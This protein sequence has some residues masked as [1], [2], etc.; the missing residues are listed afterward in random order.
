MQPHVEETER[1]QQKKTK[2]SVVLHDLSASSSP[3]VA[4]SSG[5]LPLAQCG[6]LLP[7]LVHSLRS[8]FR[9]ESLTAVQAAVLPPALQQRDVVA[10]SRT[11]SGKT[12]AYL[13]PALQSLL[14]PTSASASPPLPSTCTVLILQPTRELVLQTVNTLLRLSPSPSL[15][16]AAVYGGAS[17]SAQEAALAG[18]CHVL[19]A[20]PGRLLDFMARRC[21]SL[22]RVRLCVLDECDAMLRLGFV[23]D[24]ETVMAEMRQQGRQ[25]LLFSATMP[26][27]V[28]KVSSRHLR[29]PVTL[30]LVTQQTAGEGAGP[31]QHSASASPSSIRHQALVCPADFTSRASLIAA[32][33]RQSSSGRVI[34]F[35]SSRNDCSLLASHPALSPIAAA[36]HGEQSQQQRESVMAAFRSASSSSSSPRVL[37]ATDL[38]ARG[39]D[40]DD[41]ELV[42]HSTF[43][44]DGVELYLHRSGR[45]GRAGRAGRSVILYTARERPMLRLLAEKLAVDIE[46]LQPPQPQRR[47]D[48]ELMRSLHSL[49]SKGRA[50]QY[51]PLARRALALHGAEALAALMSVVYGGVEATR[52][53]LTGVEG[54]RCVKLR[55]SKLS[56]EQVTEAIMAAVAAAKGQR[57]EDGAEEKAEA[58]VRLGRMELTADG[59]LIDVDSDTVTLLLRAGRAAQPAGQEGEDDERLAGVLEL[60]RDLPSELWD[61]DRNSAVRTL[62]ERWESGVSRFNPLRT[63]DRRPMHELTSIAQRRQRVGLGR[64]AKGKR[65]VYAKQRDSKAR[66]TQ[67]MKA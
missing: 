6:L 12:L 62:R 4:P 37:I 14:S 64:G 16:V 19:V 29:D 17:Y 23:Q 54:Y 18:G 21:V 42:L 20:T 61:A 32:F 22:K 33:L 67:R 49:L 55:G 45:T 7:S 5:S 52:S 24:V 53:L 60:V 50:E 3:P 9:I 43:P 48:E 38:A 66:L 35:T 65:L 56:R 51:L 11:G 58:E 31:E 10:R 2:P 27:W 1:R 63:R 57:A 40:V 36:L 15:Q 34:V 47:G 13:L 30:D 26:D 41:V 28:R 25:T 46:E 8:R 44:E 59:A 39:L